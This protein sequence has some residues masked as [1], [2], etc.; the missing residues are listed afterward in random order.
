MPVNHGVLGISSWPSL[1][2]LHV[3]IS[4]LLSQAHSMTLVFFLL[5]FPESALESAFFPPSI[6]LFL[7]CGVMVA[8]CNRLGYIFSVFFVWE[9]VVRLYGLLF[10]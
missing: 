7:P 9:D 8:M 1:R 5:F 6:L 2:M 10:F 4:G 3:P